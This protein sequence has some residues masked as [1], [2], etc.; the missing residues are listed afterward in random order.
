MTG[1]GWGGGRGCTSDEGVEDARGIT[2]VSMTPSSS[3][4]CGVRNGGLDE[5][6]AREDGEA[7]EAKLVAAADVDG[8]L[9]VAYEE[10]P[11]APGT[12]PG[13]GRAAMVLAR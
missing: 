13:A 11:P 9:M 4:G 5:T 6:R 1:V 2:V 10:I 3:R 8:A 12:A 7:M